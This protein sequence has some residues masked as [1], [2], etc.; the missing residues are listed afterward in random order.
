M[1]QNAVPVAVP[2]GFL[3]PSHRSKTEG[4]TLCRLP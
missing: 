1:E 4:V 3:G 2:L